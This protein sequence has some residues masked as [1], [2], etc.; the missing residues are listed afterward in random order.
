MMRSRRTAIASIL[1]CVGLLTVGSMSGWS[2][3][4]GQDDDAVA[5]DP[6]EDQESPPPAA[7]D[8]GE[9]SFA[10]VPVRLRR[11]ERDVQSLKERAWRSKARVGLLREQVIGGGVGARVTLIHK[12]EIGQAF[13]L[14]Q[15][16]YALDGLAVFSRTDTDGE[17]HGNKTI[18]LMSGPISPGS[19]TISVLYVYRGSG[20]GPFKYLKQ[21]RYTVRSSH[22]FTANEGEHT[23][24]QI[25]GLEKGGW[26]V[27]MRNRPSVDFRVSSLTDAA[28]E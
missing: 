14:V 11:L 13:R 3:A 18:E 28:A 24:I 9:E 17:L 7:T 6:V 22:T 1:T 8:G 16:V 5:N 19:H 25:V 2:T 12:N 15:A 27:P 21:Y 4:F 20:F 23:Q 10:P 26:S